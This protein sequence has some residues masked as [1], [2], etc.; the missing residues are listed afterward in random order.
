M[1][2]RRSFLAGVL[3]AAALAAKTEK[4]ALKVVVKNQYGKPVDNAAV[5]LDF[6]GSRKVMKLGMRHKMHWEVRTNLQGIATFPPVPEGTV[7]LQVITKKY[8]TYGD[9]IELEGAE[10]TVDITL[11]PPQKQYSA[12]EPHPE[13]EKKQP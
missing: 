11:N 7:Q 5:I 8:Q 3:G 2:T 9:K 13:D 1:R 4:T 12:H 10:K 6:L